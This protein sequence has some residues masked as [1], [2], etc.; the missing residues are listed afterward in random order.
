MAAAIAFAVR[1][2]RVSARISADTSQVQTEGKP[3]ASEPYDPDDIADLPAPGRRYFETVHR[4]G[5]PH[6]KMVRLAQEG[7]FRLGDADA[8]WRPF[9]A[10]Q[11]YSISPPGNVWDAKITLLP[12]TSARVFDVYV[13]DTGLLRANHFGRISGRECGPEPANERS[14]TPAVPLGDP[15]VPDGSAVSGWPHL[16]EYR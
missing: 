14:G 10:S 4:P 5:Q 7:D 11:V 13:A 16:G 8:P 9:T 15:V 2:R 12:F 3:V 1:R 6:V